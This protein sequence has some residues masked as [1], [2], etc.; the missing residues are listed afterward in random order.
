[1]YQSKR[2]KAL[3]FLVRDCKKS[4]GIEMPGAVAECAASHYSFK[5]I[6][7]EPY[8]SMKNSDRNISRENIKYK[9]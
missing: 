9:N 1:M 7:T 5:C 3:H 6:D 8:T 2:L 4:Y